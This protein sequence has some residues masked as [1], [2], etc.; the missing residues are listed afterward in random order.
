MLHLEVRFW[1]RHGGLQMLSG[2]SSWYYMGV[3][4]NE[5]SEKVQ[6]QESAVV[7]S[8]YTCLLGELST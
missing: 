2:S 6:S 8:G 7:Q 1:A 4:I 5:G 3:L